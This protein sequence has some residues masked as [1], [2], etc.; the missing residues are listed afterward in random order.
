MEERRKDRIGCVNMIQGWGVSEQ[1]V[2]NLGIRVKLF[3][4]PESGERKRHGTGR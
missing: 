1:Q 4:V 3:V 2:D